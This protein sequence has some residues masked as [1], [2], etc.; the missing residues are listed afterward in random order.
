MPPK[1]NSQSS[2]RCTNRNTAKQ[3]QNSGGV[4]RGHCPVPKE[5]SRRK[6]TLST[7]R[8]QHMR[9]HF[10]THALYKIWHRCYIDKNEFEK[11]KI[12]LNQKDILTL[13]K[14][15]DQTPHSRIY[16]V[17]KKPSSLLSYENA[18]LVDKKQRRFL[19]AYWRLT[20][21][22]DQY[23]KYVRDFEQSVEGNEILNQ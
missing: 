23:I 17:P 6:T 9:K 12:L 4:G 21:N 3:M 22:E 1:T 7:E 8:K 19:I 16:V 2:S 13:C 5:K 15:K 11:D 20:N 10:Y 14:L 18:L